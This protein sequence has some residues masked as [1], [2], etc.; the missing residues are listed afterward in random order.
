MPGILQKKAD[1]W[2]SNRRP[3]MPAVAMLSMCEWLSFGLQRRRIHLRRA[4]RHSCGLSS[5]S[6]AS[7]A[8]ASAPVTLIFTVLT[9]C[10]PR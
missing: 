1:R 7:V 4:C 8:F 6:G 5:G 2:E 3:P 10:L 9:S